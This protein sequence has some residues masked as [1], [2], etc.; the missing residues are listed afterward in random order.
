MGPP[1]TH[2]KSPPGS[3]SPGGLFVR[4]YLVLEMKIAA[5]LIRVDLRRLEK[6]EALATKGSE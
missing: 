3:Y 6:Q 2:T 1:Q 4:C 5:K